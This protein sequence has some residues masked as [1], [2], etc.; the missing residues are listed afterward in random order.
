MYFR[1][2]L[3]QPHKDKLNINHATIR[4]PLKSMTNQI[5]AKVQYM[6][7]L[8]NNCSGPCA[9]KY[10]SEAE[11]L[12]SVQKVLVSWSCVKKYY[13]RRRPTRFFLEDSK[14]INSLWTMVKVQFYFPRHSHE[15]SMLVIVV[16]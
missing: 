16:L 3:K 13:I 4:A 9:T 15:L 8:A 10:L 6:F 1:G 12:F 7:A 2:D 14:L 11:L 5:S